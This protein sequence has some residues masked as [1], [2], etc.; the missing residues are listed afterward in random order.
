MLDIIVLV[1][2]FTVS[3]CDNGYAVTVERKESGECYEQ[4]LMSFSV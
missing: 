2:W 1:L 3:V 4:D